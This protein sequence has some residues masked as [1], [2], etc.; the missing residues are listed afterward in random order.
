MGVA[1]AMAT[2]RRREEHQAGL[3]RAARQHINQGRLSAGRRVLNELDGSAGALGRE[4]GVSASAMT[5]IADRMERVRLVKRV[6]LE[7]DR[8]VRCL[9]LTAR[10]KKMMQR[11]DEARAA[12]MAEVLSHLTPR[13]RQTAADAMQ[14]MIRAAG[15]EDG[16]D[17]L[18]GPHSVT[19]NSPL[20]HWERG[21]GRGLH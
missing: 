18:Q 15:G 9:R 11:H 21:M 12:R 5:Q 20:S 6:P 17:L 14:S 2:R 16:S 13:Q 10:G 4:L 8:R 1:Q 3:L 7:G 19:S